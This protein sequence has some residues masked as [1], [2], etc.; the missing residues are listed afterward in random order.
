MRDAPSPP[1]K[2]A[3]EGGIERESSFS[4]FSLSP[5]LCFFF[6]VRANDSVFLLFSFFPLLSLF[7]RDFFFFSSFSSCLSCFFNKKRHRCSRI[8]ICRVRRTPRG[9][10][11]GGQ[12]SEEMGRTWRALS[13]RHGWASSRVSFF[14]FLCRICLF[15][16]LRIFLRVTSFSSCVSDR[17]RFSLNQGSNMM[18]KKQGRENTRN[19]SIRKR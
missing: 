2:T 7:K 5:L 1:S 9:T 16:A 19:T 15:F 17:T 3:E 4:P 11:R 10:R 6:F 18:H 12:R 14:F 8:L 13:S